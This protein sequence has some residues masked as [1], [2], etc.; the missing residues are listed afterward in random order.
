MFIV[1]PTI[2]KEC[3]SLKSSGESLEMQ[4]KA[5]YFLHRLHQMW[6]W[7]NSFVWSFSKILTFT[8]TKVEAF[9]MQNMCNLFFIIH[10]KYKIN[11][12]S[13]HQRLNPPIV[14][15]LLKV[16]GPLSSPVCVARL[17]LLLSV[18]PGA[19]WISRTGSGRP[20]P[21]TSFP[22]PDLHGWNL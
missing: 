22:D 5:Q 8:S 9:I 21:H 4:V 12:Y 15:C 10:T 18:S 6:D 19:L 7:V 1:F 20:S 16:S 17:Y 14:F 3:L 13:K 2:V 11:N